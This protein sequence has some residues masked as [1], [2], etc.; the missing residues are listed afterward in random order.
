[1]KNLTVLTVVS[2]L[3]ALLLAGCKANDK[4]VPTNAPETTAQAQVQQVTEKAL[5]E[6]AQSVNKP[7]AVTPETPV[8]NK[9]EAGVKPAENAV[10][11]TNPPAAQ[12]V[13]VSKDE[14]KKTVLNH[15]GLK[16]A[17]VKGYRAELDRERGGLVYEVEFDSGKYEY[18]YEVSAETGKVLKSEK[19]FR[20]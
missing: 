19:E 20:D 3:V 14:V 2:V 7:E 8:E 15:A 4:P 10:K 6:A 17:E 16:E 11:P 1:M 5:P 13:K 18:D 9:Q 12:E